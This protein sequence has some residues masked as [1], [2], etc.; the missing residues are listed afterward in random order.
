MRFG[1]AILVVCL[2]VGLLIYSAVTAT[3]KS[4]VTVHELMAA[5]DAKSNIRLGARVADAPI[6]YDQD[7]VRK[8]HFVVRDIPE[9][10]TEELPVVYAGTMPDMLKAG[11]DVILEGNFDGHQFIAKNLVTQCPSKYAPPKPGEKH[12]ARP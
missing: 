10:H 12:E 11:R 3:A 4:V 6:D 8:L 5:G 7:T 9:P 1:I 2:T